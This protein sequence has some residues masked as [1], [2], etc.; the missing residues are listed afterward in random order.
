MSS[1]NDQIRPLLKINSYISS[2][3]A[4]DLFDLTFQENIYKEYCLTNEDKEKFIISYLNEEQK[5]KSDIIS[6]NDLF[7]KQITK[8]IKIISYISYKESSTSYLITNSFKY[9]QMNKNLF[10]PNV[11]ER[12]WLLFKKDEYNKINEG[13]IIKL[14]YLRIKFDKIVLENKTDE[15]MDNLS[16]DN[17]SN[18]NKLHE[19]EE[20]IHYC[21]HCFQTETNPNDPLICPCKCTNS[22]KYIHFSCLKN[23]INLKIHKKHDKYYDVYFFMSYNCD[24]CLSTFPKYITYKNK[25][26]NLLD[27]DVSNYKNY[28]LCD[29]SQY[30]KENNYIFHIGYLVIKLD[31]DIP[32]TIGRKKDNQI[33]FNEVSISRNHCEII[34][35]D[36]DIFIKDLGSKYGTFKYI[37]EEQ[38]INIGDSI[39][40][41]SGNFKF[42]FNLTKKQSL[43]DLDLIFN[44]LYKSI[45]NSSCCCSN[46]LK[47]KGDVPILQ[48]DDQINPQLN[49]NIC[50]LE[51]DSKTEYDKRFRDFDSYN[52]Y[53]I[54]M[55]EI[56]EDRE[57]DKKSINENY[58]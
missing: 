45:I 30:D 58:S 55:D 36:K 26:L 38:E 57:I 8:I 56:N 19:N 9:Q 21:R 12:I 14:G 16:N 48:N 49:S 27:I 42:D 4:S 18:T 22:L 53:I 35:K 46:Y 41:I 15:S 37:K 47:D 50:I 10:K 24:I 51:K 32:L 25:N 33:T 23:T 13:D 31:E 3:N 7:Q 6:K 54:N 5:I 28:I 39:T 40:L 52:D 11:C 20:N 17:N 34:K 43:F 29:M 2:L 44:N 1:K